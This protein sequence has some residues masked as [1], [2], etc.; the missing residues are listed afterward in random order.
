MYAT[1]FGASVAERCR[2]IAGILP[3]V[4]GR[5]CQWFVHISGQNQTYYILAVREGKQR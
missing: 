4:A 2:S 1:R 5:L 3:D